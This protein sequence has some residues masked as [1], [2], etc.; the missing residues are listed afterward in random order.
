MHRSSRN[1][2]KRVC[3]HS[4]GIVPSIELSSSHRRV[5]RRPLGVVAQPL[6]SVPDRRFPAATSC[7][8]EASAAH[9]AGSVPLMLLRWNCAH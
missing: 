9:D 8:N 3:A 5:N 1:S 2:S 7:S 6:G 4:V